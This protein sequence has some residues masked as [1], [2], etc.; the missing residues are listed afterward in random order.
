MRIATLA[1][2]TTLLV[3][4]IQANAA[5]T[6][7]HQCDVLAA[8]PMD[9]EK[10][11]D[12]VGISGGDINV[13]EALKACEAAVSSA[14]DDARMNFNLGRIL[15]NANQDLPR[16][17]TLFQKSADKG[18]ALAMTNLGYAFRNGIGTPVDNALA[19]KWDRAAAE[20]GI[21]VAQ[22]NLAILYRDGLGVAQDYTEAAKWFQKAADSGYADATN[23]LA[24]AYDHGSGVTQDYA[25]ARE[26]YQKA[27]DQ[28]S[29]DALSG[30]G[31]LYDRGLGVPLDHVKANEYYRKAADEGDAQGMDNLAESMLLG[32]GIAKDEVAGWALLNKAMEA[33]NAMATHNVAM[34]FARG[35]HSKKDAAKAAEYFL[36]AIERGS[37][38]SIKVLITDHGSNLDAATRNAVQ[39]ALLAKGAAFTREQ[40]TLSDSAVAALR[41][42]KN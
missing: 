34:S 20:K 5:V 24:I 28:G 40:G 26:L 6:D 27:I 41:K 22:N 31:F 7:A 13:P 1:I 35:L 37:D 33:G 15:M 17:L 36:L 25:K 2:F 16:M 10:P 30:L 29:L 18:S 3:C 23:N 21:A 42:L 11:A 39:D 8:S 38:D 32:E 12:V 4:P 14:P 9:K 19:A